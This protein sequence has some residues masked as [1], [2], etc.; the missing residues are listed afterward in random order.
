MAA[1]AQS[2]EHRPA[3][4][5]L[6]VDDVSA[7]LQ[8]ITRQLE[9]R[10]YV[11]LVARSG[12][13]AIQR[14]ELT[15]PD[16]ILL[17][18]VM[19][20]LDG[21]ETCRRLKQRAVTRDI[22]V[23]FM[24]ALTAT[25]DKVEGFRVGA[26]DYVTKP[27][28]A[29]EVVARVAT[30]LTLDALRQQLQSSNAELQQLTAALRR[31]NAELEQLAY[32]ASHDMQEPLRMVASYLQLV[33]QRY[34]DRLDADGHEFIGYAVDGAKRMQAMINDLLT[35]SRV[36][37]KARPFAPTDCAKCV[38][39]ARI[40]LQVAIA[41]SGATITTDTLPIVQGDPTQLLQLFQNLI[42]NAIKFRGELAPQVH[43]GAQ[44]TEEGWHFSV[45]DNGIGIAPEHFE[46]IF[47]LFQRL[48]G[49]N[50]YP[51]T[52]IGLALC[53][54]IVERHGGHIWVESAPGRGSTFRF[55]LPRAA[56][57]G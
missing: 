31:S 55:T 43:V 48:H 3:Q 17:D 25:D 38:S 56:A 41:E 30:H 6:I 10:G 46:R 52:G 9:A 7:N 21:F 42:A 34:G 16:L 15:H 20:G 11:V 29:D 37:T 45:S 57:K 18:V 33:A 14:A 19:P 51:G 4:S 12:L 50:Q 49:R 28:N 40:Q 2:A 8:V 44:A 5:I 13:E 36:S 26:V 32:V 54:R 53:K 1:N 23:I 39:T 24:T 35:L 47:V 22:P 27:L